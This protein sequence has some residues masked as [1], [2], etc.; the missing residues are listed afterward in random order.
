MSFRIQE[1]T[2]EEQFCEQVNLEVLTQIIPQ[3]TIESVIE[4]C[5][6]RE[7]RVRKLPAWLTILLCV[8][9]N[10]MSELRISHVLLRLSKGTRWLHQKPVDVVASDSSI[11]EARYQV[12]VKPLHRLFQE[13][14]QPIGNAVTPGTFALGFRLVAI[15]GMIQD[16]ADTPEN[17]AYFG[18]PGGSVRSPWPQVKGVY[19]CE[20]G[21]HVIFD[22]YL[23]PYATSEYKGAYRLLRSIT[24][25]MLVMVDQGLYS[26][27]FFMKIRQKGAHLL[28]RVP[29]YVKPE[30]I[31]T[32]SDGSFLA[33]IAP[34]DY[35]RRKS[36][37]KLLVR[38][39]QYV[40]ED[41]T[42]PG[43]NQIHRLVTTLLDPELYPPL[44]LIDLYHERWEEEIT[45]DE[46]ET[47]LRLLDR[48]LRSLKP[49]GVLQE[50][51]ALLLAHFVIRSLMFQAASDAQIDPDRLS[52]THAVRLISD[53]IPFFQLTHPQDH[54]ALLHWLL[55]DIVHPRF[56]LP[57]RDNRINPRVVKRRT[58]RYPRKRL[59]DYALPQPEKPFRE[60]VT[61]VPL[62][63]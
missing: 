37:E 48:P 32:L 36:G 47:H 31:C 44:T 23:A 12:G 28:A 2:E 22:A 56:R 41:P 11:S 39:I 18:R 9:M 59:Q 21:T 5:Q 24:P 10:I 53:A 29:S 8:G 43:H 7:K 42:R 38:I 60:V 52:F 40:I 62:P 51:Y 20:V 61:L 13:V 25:E 33:A 1:I 3:E 16:V 58:S 14:C 6:V 15:D 46:I 4:M 54:D 57:P 30:Y 17:E 63:P 50:L 45:F 49:L 19:L 55:S 35:Q 27:D 34:A 26:A